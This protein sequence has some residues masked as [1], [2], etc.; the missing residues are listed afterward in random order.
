MLLI[1][2]WLSW[3]KRSKKVQQK[4]PSVFIF[5]FAFFFPFLAA[6]YVPHA[7]FKMYDCLFNVHVNSRCLQFKLPE[8]TFSCLERLKPDGMPDVFYR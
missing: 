4:G 1:K 8:N 2:T 6:F 7:G 5:P 3:A